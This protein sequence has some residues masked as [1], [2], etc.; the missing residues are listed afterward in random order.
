MSKDRKIIY[1]LIGV[2]SGILVYVGLAGSGCISIAKM[3]KE[4]LGEWYVSTYSAADN[5]P[6]G[7]YATSS[8]RRATAGRTVAVDKNN[9]L[10]PMGSKIFIEGVGKRVVEDYGGFGRYNNGRRAVDVFTK[11]HG[12]LKY[13]RIYLF[14]K[15]TKK[16]RRKR[17]QKL[18]RAV[19]KAERNQRLEMQKQ[20]MILVYSKDLLP[21]QVRTTQ[22]VVKGGTV[23]LK[24][25]SRYGWLDVKEVMHGAARIVWSGDKELC[26]RYTYVHFKEV[27]ENAKG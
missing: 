25:I 1:F 26:S 16:E 23:S 12:Y 13:C 14:R 21:W 6:R 19:R 24:E 20:P 18:I 27:F 4:P 22:G 7:S 2:L 11:G 9:P 10:V 3:V 15:E 17:I 8:G 5:T